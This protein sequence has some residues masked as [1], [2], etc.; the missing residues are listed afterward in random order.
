FLPR[1]HLKEKALGIYD[2]LIFASKDKNA[3]ESE[4]SAQVMVE[5]AK[6][7]FVFGGEV[8]GET[9]TSESI[10]GQSNAWDEYVPLTE[11]IYLSSLQT[12]TV[13]IL[14]NSSFEEEAGDEPR[15]WKYQHF[16][17]SANTSPSDQIYRS[18]KKGLL[19]SGSSSANFGVSQPNV[20]LRKSRTYTLSLYVRPVNASSATVK[21][22]FWDSIG[23]KRAEMKDFS[24]SGTG[25]W[26]RISMNI[27]NT[28]NWE[29]KEWFPIIEVMGL[30]SGTLVLED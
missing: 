12:T 13:N 24:F 1:F 5:K 19:I 3:D 23:N 29:G 15:Q 9:E 27:D 16:S 8:L 6:T 11:D 14:R 7:A 2:K 10:G 4:L 28:G 22:G 21:I 20:K 30:T 17:D 25:E 26:Q 18:G